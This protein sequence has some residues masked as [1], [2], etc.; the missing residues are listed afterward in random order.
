[1]VLV[2]ALALSLA[3]QSPVGGRSRHRRANILI[4]LTDD[5]RSGLQVM[6]GVRHKLAKQGR[7]FPHAFVTTPACCPSRASI[8]TGRYAHNHGVVRNPLDQKL[9]HKTTLQ[10]FLES[11]GYRT[12]YVGKFLNDWPIRK[13]PPFFD[14]WATHSAS[15]KSGRRRYY[16]GKFNING[17]VRAVSEYSTNFVG[18]RAVKFLQTANRRDRRPWLLYVATDAPHA[19]LIPARKYRNTRVP[20]WSG[21]P[22]VREDDRSDKPPWVRSS[23]YTFKEGRE[24]RREQFRML[25]SVDDMIKKVLGVVR[26]LDERRKTLVIF[27]SDNG[28][29]WSEHRLKAKF[30]PYTESIRVPMV[31]R[32]P[33]RIGPRSK[34]RRLTGNIDIAP[35]VL[36]AANVPHDSGPPFDGRS[37]LKQGWAREHLLFEYARHAYASVPKWASIR[38]KSYQYVEYYGDGEVKFREYY[39][40]KR[41]RYQLRNLLHDGNPNDPGN[42]AKVKR[43]LRRDKNCRGADCP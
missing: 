6:D 10:Y 36:D 42:L 21:N 12:G 14:A 27:M 13:D 43:R 37:L 7:S 3:P 32:W 38:S 16:D 33:G 26:D 11:A 5:Q 28:Y 9:N 17:D 24:F 15:P 22:A 19:P 23:T 30:H 39:K 20:S 40:L 31:M 25:M 8:M 2:L 41:D 4:F 35:T 34:D 18:S 1:M 29:L